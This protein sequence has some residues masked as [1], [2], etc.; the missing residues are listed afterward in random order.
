MAEQVYFNGNIFTQ[1]PDKPRV[2]AVAC[3]NGRIAAAG[4]YEDVK[5]FISEGTEVIDL[6]GKFV[7]PGFIEDEETYLDEEELTDKGFTS[8]AAFDGCEPD[9]ASCTKIR[10]LDN[11]CIHRNSLKFGNCDMAKDAIRQLTVIAAEELGRDD[12]G[13][14][15]VGRLA[16]FT[17]FEENPIK[18]NLRYF[19]NMHAEQTIIGGVIVYDAEEA[20]MDEM[21]SLMTEMLV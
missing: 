12:I 15:E 4:R 14:I 2:S 7:F 17:V 13:M 1:N 6:Q 8:I 9:R 21:Y 16:D 10:F 3:E 11:P 5:P 19:T 18:K 20:L